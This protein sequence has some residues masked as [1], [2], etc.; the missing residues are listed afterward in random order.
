MKT[1][2][3]RLSGRRVAVTGAL[4]LASAALAA[5]PAHAKGSVDVTAPG[6][7]AVGKTFSVTAQGNDDAASY[8]R[9]CLEGRGAGKAWHQLACG[10]TV[11]WGGSDAQVTAKAKGTQRGALEFRAVL[12]ALNSP[13]DN[14]PVRMRGSGVVKVQVR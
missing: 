8:M 14:H 2:T 4:G 13:S 6:T 9:I 11:E 12:Y 7:A 1:G 3:K 5:V 10:A